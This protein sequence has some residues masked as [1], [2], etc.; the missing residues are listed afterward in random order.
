VEGDGETIDFSEH[1]PHS[2]ILMA[3][4]ETAEEI[5]QKI[6]SVRENQAR[7]QTEFVRGAWGEEYTS[8]MFGVGLLDAE[9]RKTRKKL[10]RLRSRARA[11]RLSDGE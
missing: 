3:R 8:T 5:E 1:P 10:S 7:K 9:D 4:R 6:E 11:R 2:T